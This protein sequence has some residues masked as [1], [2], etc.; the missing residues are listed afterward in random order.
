MN[1]SRE[2]E[3][4]NRVSEAVREIV[5]TMTL[6]SGITLD[7]LAL[8]PK[9]ELDDYSMG[10][11]MTSRTL[12]K[13]RTDFPDAVLEHLVKNDGTTI[14]LGNGTSLVPLEVSWKQ[15]DSGA[16][17]NQ[18]I[19]I[20]QVNL[21]LLLEDLTEIESQLR[22]RGFL[23]T[24][25]IGTQKDRVQKLVD[26]SNDSAQNF[27]IKAGLIGEADFSDVEGT[28]DIVFNCYGPAIKTLEHQL[29]MVKPGGVLYVTYYVDD[30][31]I[32]AEEIGQSAF[33]MIESITPMKSIVRVT[34]KK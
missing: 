1:M 5:S 8:R 3:E 24:F 27:S 28:G 22:A 18:K 34:R 9:H 13:L 6:K 26:A 16:I 23:H 29:Q 12:E 17:Q 10:S 19:A 25:D 4:K 33:D 31:R 15:A 30:F 14:F 2:R 20:D 32:E 7:G 21:P 11:G